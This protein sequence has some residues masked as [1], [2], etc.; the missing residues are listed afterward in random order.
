MLPESRIC[1]TTLLLDEAHH[2]LD[3][4]EDGADIVGSQLNGGA[5]D[6]LSI[7]RNGAR[8]YK[9]LRGRAL[10]LICVIGVRWETSLQSRRA[11]LV[12]VE[13]ITPPDR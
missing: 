8:A 4:Q 13:R 1:G 3:L 6:D 7:G 11:L 10:I 12:F 9:P 2:L 5:A